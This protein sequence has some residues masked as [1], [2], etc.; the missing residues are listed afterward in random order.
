VEIV[1]FVVV[2]VVVAG[3]EIPPRFSVGRCLLGRRRR[4]SRMRFTE[5]DPIPGQAWPSTSALTRGT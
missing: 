2:V 3:V 5:S 4:L 1:V